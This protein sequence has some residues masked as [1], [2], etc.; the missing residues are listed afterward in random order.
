[1]I[2]GIPKELKRNEYRVA[3][4]PSG[5]RVIIERGH[6]VLVEYGAGKGSGFS[7]QDYENGGAK[8][9]NAEQVYSQSEMIYKVKEILPQEYAYMREGLI[10]FTY[11]HTN[12]YIEM[13][14]I[15]LKKNVTGIA[16]SDVSDEK[17]KFPLLKPMSE[18]AGK[19]GFI[20]GLNLMQSINGGN[21]RLL[22]RIHGCQTPHVT[23]IGA[24]SAGLGAADLA[25][26]F[27]NQVSIL[28]IDLDRLEQLK[29]QLAPNV[30]LLYSS[31]ENLVRCLER[32]DLL[33]NCILWDK[34]RKDHLVSRKDL[35]LMNADSIIV[36]VA[37]DDAGAIE[38]CCSTTHADPIYYE[39]GIMHYCVDNIP[40]GFSRTASIMLSAATLPYALAIANKGVDAAITNDVHLRR[41]LTFYNGDLTLKETADKHN[42]VY[43]D[44]LE[45]I[46][47]NK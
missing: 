23:I 33:I 26:G 3:L 17:G 4:T 1:M 31:R 19:G 41:G 35:E 43:T 8:L 28:D 42:L 45:S 18:L 39:E 7:D 6:V 22:A 40:S 5:V 36:D 15:M 2:I 44:P 16:Y 30:E 47:K 21:G 25:I 34:T 46:A 32:T 37:C 12:A 38:T 11:L 14:E 9:L 24:G 29:Y 10:V 13:T 20:A 27:G